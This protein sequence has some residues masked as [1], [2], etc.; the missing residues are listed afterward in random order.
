MF[1]YV[2]VTTGISTAKTVV[3]RSGKAKLSERYPKS[4]SRAKALPA[5]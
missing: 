3:L 5:I 4:A 2:G 1:E